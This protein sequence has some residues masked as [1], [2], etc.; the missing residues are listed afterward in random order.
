MA[1]RLRPGPDPNV[2]N[3]KRLCPDSDTVDKLVKYNIYARKEIEQFRKMNNERK[4][5]DK[6]VND[7]LMK[8]HGLVKELCDDRELLKEENEKLKGF[9][10]ENK[11]L[12]EELFHLNNVQTAMSG[13]MSMLENEKDRLT[14]LCDAYKFTLEDTFQSK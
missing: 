13:E 3:N 6:Q 5:K 4:R 9:K 8:L 10:G 7:M 12:K 1:K 2:Y 14:M 11:K